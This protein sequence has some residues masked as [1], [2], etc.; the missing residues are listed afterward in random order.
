MFDAEYSE[1]LSKVQGS[2]WNVARSASLLACLGM[3]LQEKCPVALLSAMLIIHEHHEPLTIFRLLSHEFHRPTAMASV[4]T[5]SSDFELDVGNSRITPIHSRILPL[6]RAW[7]IAIHQTLEH[8]GD[9]KGEVM[10]FLSE[11]EMLGQDYQ[12]EAS[13]L[14]KLL[15]LA[16]DSSTAGTTNHNDVTLLATNDQPYLP[17]A[18]AQHNAMY[19]KAKQSVVTGEV[20]IPKDIAVALA[21]AQLVVEESERRKLQPHQRL[22][23]GPTPAFKLK[24]IMPP[25]FTRSRDVP[26]LIKFEYQ[27]L[28]HKSIRDAKHTYVHLYNLCVTH[29]C[30]YFTVKQL[31]DNRKRVP[32]ILGISPKFIFVID[33]KTKH[34]LHSNSLR[35]LARWDRHRDRPS[36]NLFSVGKSSGQSF[37]I[38]YFDT[39][40]LVIY[41]EDVVLDEISNMLLCNTQRLVRADESNNISKEHKPKETSKLQLPQSMAAAEVNHFCDK[42]SSHIKAGS[43]EFASTKFQNVTSETSVPLRATK[44][45]PIRISSP[46]SFDNEE[47]VR[48]FSASISTNLKRRDDL[49][50]RLEAASPHAPPPSPSFENDSN[51]SSTSPSTLSQPKS[52]ENHET[53]SSFCS[54]SNTRSS[55]SGSEAESSLNFSREKPTLRSRLLFSG[56]RSSIAVS[57]LRTSKTERTQQNSR[58]YGSVSGAVSSPPDKYINDCKLHNSS[59]TTPMRRRYSDVLPSLWILRRRAARSGQRQLDSNANVKRPA[60]HAK[61]D[62]T[63]IFHGQ[64]SIERSK[65]TAAFSVTRRVSRHQQGNFSLTRQSFHTLKSCHCPGDPEISPLIDL[66]SLTV[67]DLLQSPLE[68]ARQLTLFE[69]HLFRKVTVLSC[70]QRLRRAAAVTRVSASSSSDTE[71]DA[72]GVLI[73]RFNEISSW[74][75]TIILAEESQEQRCMVIEQLLRT[76]DHLFQLKN[77][78]GVMEIVS[79]LGMASI[80]RLTDTWNAVSPEMQAVHMRLSGLME[81]E[82]NFREYRLTLGK[83]SPPCVPYF[84]MYL[85]DLTFLHH[86]NQDYGRRGMLNIHKMRQFGAI[87]QNMIKLQEGTYNLLL[88]P[89]FC[90]FLMSVEYKTDD[91]LFRDSQRLQPSQS[92]K[93]GIPSRRGSSAPRKHSIAQILSS[94][95]LA[96]LMRGS[97]PK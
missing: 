94:S 97:Q 45:L 37:L 29:D 82:H 91:E 10:D 52:I 57:P 16:T 35:K 31:T 88:V 61:K 11:M 13:H 55:M 74:V 96:S 65:S 54:R 5:V 8:R 81:A 72:V 60:E 85:R 3:L 19:E 25:A 46:I 95:S 48:S 2:A 41:A 6:L 9:I 64:K 23:A 84:G 12:R 27:N 39:R 33:A 75:A 7:A 80:Q 20:P 22:P 42:D 69:H 26:N 70:F 18:E 76:A 87:L 83:V 4:D 32:R 58:R 89:E 44:E 21:A 53:D 43:S 77:F 24:A 59:E 49:W 28:C 79:A 38:F 73:S 36:W 51:F 86:G 15:C 93:S 30:T 1:P 66:K 68:L 56:L 34:V 62:S 78:N 17:Y 71:Q 63:V 50:L 90:R 40:Q 47:R 14:R 67:D 92:R